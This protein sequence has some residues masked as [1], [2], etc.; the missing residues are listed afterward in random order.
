MSRRFIAL[1]LLA[2]ALVVRRD[3]HE[4]RAAVSLPAHRTPT[5]RTGTRSAPRPSPRRR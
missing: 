5:S 3:R 4:Q 2:A 1:A